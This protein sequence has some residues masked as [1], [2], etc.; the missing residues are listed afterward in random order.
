MAPLIALKQFGIERFNKE[1]LKCDELSINH[2][3]Q[4]L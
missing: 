3:E 2:G 1:L 4:I